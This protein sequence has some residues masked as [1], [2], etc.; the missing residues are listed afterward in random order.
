[1]L[2]R[3]TAATEAER[4]TSAATTSS[5]STVRSLPSLGA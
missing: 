2:G 3:C 5:V 1:L 4:V